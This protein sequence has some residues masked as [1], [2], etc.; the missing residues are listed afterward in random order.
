MADYVPHQ[1]FDPHSKTRPLGGMDHQLVSEQGE[2][3]CN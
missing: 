2:G 1:G 3:L